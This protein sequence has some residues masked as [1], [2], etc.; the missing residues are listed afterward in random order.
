MLALEGHQRKRGTNSSN[1]WAE[2]TEKGRG[3]RLPREHLAAVD[4]RLWEKPEHRE[5]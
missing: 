2:V 5:V 3:L 1:G 4:G